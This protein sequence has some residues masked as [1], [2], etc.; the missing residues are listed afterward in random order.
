MLAKE[1]QP[2]HRRNPRDNTG[3]SRVDK[4]TGRTTGTWKRIV[5]LYY[6]FIKP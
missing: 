5:T 6:I 4:G 1:I 3:S 2:G